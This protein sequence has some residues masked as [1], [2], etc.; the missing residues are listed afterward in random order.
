MTRSTYSIAIAIITLACWP[1]VWT[2]PCWGD[3]VVL[4]SAEQWVAVDQNEPAEFTQIRAD[5]NNGQ[6]RRALN[7]IKDWIEDH[8]DSPYIDQ[9]LHIQA[10]VLIARGKHY[11]A[12]EIY[13]QLLDEHSN[14]QLFE[15]ALREEV[16]IARLFLAGQKRTVLGIL[17]VT[18]RAEAIVMLDG[19]VERWPGSELA[20]QALM[21]QADYYFQE[22]RFVESQEIYQT[23]VEYYGHSEYYP[24]AMLRRAESSFGQYYGPEYDSTCLDDAYIRYLE[25]EAEFPEQA[26]QNNVAERLEEIINEQIRKE[27]VVA[28]YYERTGRIP[29]AVS[30]WQMIVERWPNTTWAQQSQ[31]LLAS[32]ADSEN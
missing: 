15:T 1:N 32:Y 10:Q 28:D 13:E 21:M 11:D 4:G 12:Y 7:Q 26:L 9:A 5:L 25:F 24:T 31:E 18:A 27:F 16:D 30:Y 19:V 17:R 22:G 6:T 3:T 14:S 20:C 23:V 2:N 8:P 29:A